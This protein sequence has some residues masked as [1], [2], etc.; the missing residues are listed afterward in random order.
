MSGTYDFRA[1]S[2]EPVAVDCWPRDASLVTASSLLNVW[3]RGM[4]ELCHVTSRSPMNDGLGDLLE[5]NA[6]G[7]GLPASPKR[8]PN[9][10]ETVSKS[11]STGCGLGA[12][13]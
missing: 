1:S 13:E 10:V 11:W 12:R 9:I 3:I 6:R 5:L 4:A 2:L 7:A 8:F